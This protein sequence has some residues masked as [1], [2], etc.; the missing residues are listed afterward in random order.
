MVGTA[1]PAAAEV[2]EYCSYWLL[3]E[4]CL[5]RIYKDKTYIGMECI[6][7]PIPSVEQFDFVALGLSPLVS[8]GERSVQRKGDSSKSKESDSTGLANDR[9]VF[10]S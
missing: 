1:A 8:I 6:A 2:V 5:E 10:E 4:F 9:T 3:L 7:I